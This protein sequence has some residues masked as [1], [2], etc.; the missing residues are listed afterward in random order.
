MDQV[1]KFLVL[2]YLFH[3]LVLIPGLLVLR[4]VQN[5]GAA[6]GLLAQRNLFLILTGLA[7]VI[8]LLLAQKRIGEASLFWRVGTGLILGGTLGNL[9]DRVRLGHV[10]DFIDVGFWPV[11]NLADVAITCGV[12]IILLGVLRER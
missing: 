1:S 4:Y 7:L 9:I 8:T 6:F 11:F 3:P 12:G 5:P 10:V 2:S